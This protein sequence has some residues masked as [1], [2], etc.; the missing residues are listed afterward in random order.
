VVKEIGM[1][2]RGVLSQGCGLVLGAVGLL[3]CAGPLQMPAPSVLNKPVGLPL[4]FSPQDKARWEPV[5]LPGKGLTE[6][7]LAR[8]GGK[9]ALMA[10]AQSSASMMRQALHVPADQLGRLQFQWQIEGLIAQADMRER[11]SEDSPVRLILAF[12]GDRGRFSAKNAMLSE[13]TQ[14]LTGEPLPFATLMYVWCNRCP[15]ES[16]IVNPRTDRIRKLVVES[17]PDHVK[18]WRHYQRDVR[19]DFE[20]AFGEAPGALVGM[21]IMTD[22]DNT[23][24]EVRAWYGD[25]RLD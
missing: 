2:V 9:A 1:G 4:L 25:I 17:G 16:V 15:V 5:K 19:A 6:F 3:G 23:R 22:S 21:A 24:S 7:K 13:L 11:D 18:Q 10:H 20:K 14:A 8:Q 12:E